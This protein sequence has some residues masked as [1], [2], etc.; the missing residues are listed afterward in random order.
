MIS[1]KKKLHFFFSLLINH[2]LL[3]TMSIVT[4]IVTTSENISAERRLEKGWTIL[5]LKGKL[6][7]ITGTPSNTQKLDLYQGDIH[8]ASLVDDNAL[9][10]A[11]PFE[12]FMRL[13]V[14]DTNP[15]R[16]KNQYTDV[17]LVEK[18]ELS[19]ED[20]RNRSDTVRAFKERNK[21]GRFSAEAQEQ[22]AQFERD[23]E[24]A[25]SK[26]KV[27]DRC[28]VNLGDNMDDDTLG[29]RGTVRFL[30]PT[31]FQSGTWVG[32]QYDEP[33][34]KNDGSVKGV[35]YFSCPP[36]YGTFVRPI[37]VTVGDFPEEEL[38]LTDD[39]LEEM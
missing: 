3:Y 23:N 7:P 34:G 33:L 36:K 15:H 8:I 32:I 31:E 20:Y 21:L 37:K 10:G 24:E 12:N 26:I 35:R 25:A 9:V 22:Q 29:R 13:H 2:L 27:G 19:E 14:T 16:V 6:E 11:Y 38:L 1:T 39:E 30:G 17:S 28:L 18:F 5:D 4:V